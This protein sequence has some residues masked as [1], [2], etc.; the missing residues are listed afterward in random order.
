ISSANANPPSKE[1][2]ITSIYATKIAKELLDAGSVEYV[3]VPIRD[4][5]NEDDFFQNYGND[6]N[7]YLNAL[8]SLTYLKKLNLQLDGLVVYENT[9]F[10]PYISASTDLKTI[11]STSHI[12]NLYNFS[13]GPKLGGSNFNFNVSEPQLNLPTS[14]IEDIFN[15]LNPDS[16][17]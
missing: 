10:R 11:P 8:S 15:N 1:Q 12:D 5:S 9:S 13:T 6:R 17:N 3:V 14:N 16:F 4:L 2:A 7:Y